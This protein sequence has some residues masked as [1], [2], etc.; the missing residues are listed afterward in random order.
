M[1][2]ALTLLDSHCD[3]VGSNCDALGLVAE[4]FQ[5]VEEPDQPKKIN[6]RL[7]IKTRFISGFV[8][9][10]WYG[11]LSNQCYN[12]GLVQIGP[13][14]KENLGNIFPRSFAN[15]KATQCIKGG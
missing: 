7:A 14:K 4:P 15:S 8:C 2:S 3:L 11:G 13:L 12:L 5:G 6:E 10:K 9:S 1:Y